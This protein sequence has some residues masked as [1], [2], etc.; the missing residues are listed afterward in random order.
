VLLPPKKARVIISA[1]Y[2]GQKLNTALQQ[3]SVRSGDTVNNLKLLIFSDPEAAEYQSSEHRR[4]R[5]YMTKLGSRGLLPPCPPRSQT[6]AKN[7]HKFLGLFADFLRCAYGC[8]LK[9]IRD[10]VPELDLGEAAIHTAIPLPVRTA[11]EEIHIVL[12]AVNAAGVPKPYVVDEPAAALAY[13]I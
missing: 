13:H 1:R 8:I 6:Y 3:G 12:A 2:G 4:V 7:M 11:P 5:N 10:A 9:S